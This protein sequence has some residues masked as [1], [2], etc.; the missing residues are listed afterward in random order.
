MVFVEYL[1][2]VRQ[3]NVEEVIG[4]FSGFLQTDASSIYNQYD[5]SEK[6]TIVPCLAH[7]R[8][9]FVEVVKN[10]HTKKDSCFQSILNDINDIFFIETELRSYN[11]SEEEFVE[12]RKKHVMPLLDETGKFIASAI[13]NV[14]V[15]STFGKA[16]N[17][18]S[19]LWSKMYNFLLH[20]RL[21]SANIIVENQIRPIRLLLNNAL[22]LGS[23][24]CAKAL[25]I[26]CSLIETSK[27]SEIEPKI[28]LDHTFAK[29][30]NTPVDQLHSLLPYNC[31]L[32]KTDRYKSKYPTYW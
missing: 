12:I 25:A 23:P 18:A 15:S 31:D 28:Y 7:I 8:R 11:L 32:P 9:K 17:Y 19:K 5:S 2:I 30:K 16:L 26:L 20:Y 24:K 10:I 13:H 3:K 22:F 29:I 14:H 4:N 6:I 21:S 1:Y 27:L